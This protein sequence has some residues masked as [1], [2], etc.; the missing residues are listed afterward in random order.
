MHLGEPSPARPLWRVLPAA[1]VLACLAAA[2]RVGVPFTVQRV[3]DAVTSKPGPGTGP[4]AVV[5]QALVLLVLAA[6]GAAGM[7]YLLARGVEA[8]LADIRSRMMR[9]LHVLTPLDRQCYSRGGLVSRLTY[10]VDQITNFVQRG[11][12][13]MLLNGAQLFLAT[14]LMLHYS[15]VLGLLVLMTL[16][17]LAW[18]LPALQKRLAVRFAR[19]QERNGAVVALAGE[20]VAGAAVIRAFSVQQRFDTRLGEAIDSHYVAQNRAQKAAAYAYVIGEAAVAVTTAVL[21]VVGMALGAA[22][23]LTLGELTAFLFLITMFVQPLQAVAE[24]LNGIQNAVAS[25]RRIRSLMR[26]RPA[27]TPAVIGAVPLPP[28]PLDVEVR[29]VTFAYAGAQRAALN[30]LTLRV[31]PGSTTAVVGHTG[32]GKSTLVT[33][34]TRV[35]DPDRGE[36]CI[37]GVPLPRLSEGGLRGALHLV[38]QDGF[39]FRD[40]LADNVRQACPELSDGDVME[41]FAALGLEEWLTTLPDGVRTNVGES[42]T[43]LSAGERQL[44]AIAR[45][46]AAD[47]RVLLLDEA[48][49][50]LDPLT[51]ARVAKAVKL[52][53]RDRTTIAVA[54]R[55]STAEQADDVVVMEDGQIIQRGPHSALSVCSGPYARLYADWQRRTGTVPAGEPAP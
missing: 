49:S 33:L 20:A 2:G 23:R 15:W 5:A 1:G 19:V 38:P 50:Q 47:P 40:T 42:G 6:V 14:G 29:A 51:E 13:H 36:V 44:V 9:H 43:A 30:D 27:V 34:L 16:A 25:V 4:E 10:D 41:I 37:G 28:G 45:A 12:T 46:Y 21:L 3:T 18:V 8:V 31:R 35:A 32:S 24:N 11:G 52:L 22:H 55:L 39:L 17:P 53:A 54:H 26:H 7:A 48:T